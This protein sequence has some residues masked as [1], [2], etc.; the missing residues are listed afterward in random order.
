MIALEFLKFSSV[1]SSEIVLS[2]QF[3]SRDNFPLC[4]TQMK[5]LVFE[6]GVLSQRN[7]ASGNVQS[8]VEIIILWL[9]NK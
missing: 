5:E 9:M 1:L 7:S 6:S 3:A 4:F 8:R 2:V